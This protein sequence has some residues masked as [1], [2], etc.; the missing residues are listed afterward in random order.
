MTAP[1]GA[2]P[3]VSVVVVAHNNWPDLELAIESALCQSWPAKEVIV[4]DNDSTDQSSVEIHRLFADRIRYVRQANTLDGGGYNRGIAEA[5][6]EFVQLLDGDDLL[7]PNKIARQMAVFRERADADIVYGETRQ[8]QGGTGRPSWS[9]WKTTTHDDM[10]ATLIDPAGQGA[11]LVPHCV[12]F[13]RSV[14]ERVGQW[15]ETLFGA[16]FDYWLRSAWSGCVFVFSP[17][18]WCFHRRRPSQMSADSVAMVNR[19][20]TTLQKALTYI[21]REPYQSMLRSRLAS[22]RYAG[23]VAD[24]RLKRREALTE[25]RSA[26]T[27]DHRRISAVP[28]A[29]A[30]AA[31]TIPGLRKV[32]KTRLMSGARRRLAHALGVL[33]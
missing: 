5:K 25:L 23:A 16:D 2:H 22:L 32:F 30:F 13:R 6:G 10:L 1:A 21:D 24:L 11:G 14:F 17:G 12:L 20:V 19:T 8:I 7:A 28:Y 15:D 18:A 9:D 27:L 4:V 31:V 33:D 3:L 29:I 26:R